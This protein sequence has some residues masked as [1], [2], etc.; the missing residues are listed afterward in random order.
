MRSHQ[1]GKEGEDFAADLLKA[2]GYVLIEAN[3][4]T[5]AG[6]IDLVARDGDTVCFVEV[7]TRQDDGWDAF[8]AVDR[9]KQGRIRRV[10]RQF[11]IERFHSEDVASRFDVLGIRRRAD[12]TLEGELIQD[13]FGI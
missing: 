2:R 3:Y 5:K 1:L 6:E 12:G 4:R 8:E 11:L 10:A 7:K 9:R 13:A